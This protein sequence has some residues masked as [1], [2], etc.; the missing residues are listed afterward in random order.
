MVAISFERHHSSAPGSGEGNPHVPNSCFLLLIS[1]ARG[2]WSTLRQMNSSGDGSESGPGSERVSWRLAP[3]Y[4]W[5]QCITNMLV[6]LFVD[7]V[8]TV[9]I[10]SAIASIA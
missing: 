6:V 2:S 8:A 9:D 1:V 5:V 7:V 10:A 3:R 4:S